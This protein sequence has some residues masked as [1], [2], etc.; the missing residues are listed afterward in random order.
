M[1]PSAA[2]VAGG[3]FHFQ[4]NFPSTFGA[5]H[6]ALAAILHSPDKNNFSAQI[7]SA[8]YVSAKYVSVKYTPPSNFIRVM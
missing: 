8:K 1:S 2:N 3:F 4:T 7:V 6:Q 5:A